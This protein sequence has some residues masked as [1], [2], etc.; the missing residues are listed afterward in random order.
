MWQETLQKSKGGGSGG[1]SR[2][3]FLGQYSSQE[4][5]KIDISMYDV[6]SVDDVIIE[7]TDY[8]GIGCYATMPEIRNVFAIYIDS[9]IGLGTKEINDGILTIS[10]FSASANNSQAVYGYNTI[11][12]GMSITYATYNVY[13]ISN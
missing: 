1:G 8:Q 10:P 2:I 3:N 12:F 9:S 11:P 6:K 7:I 4:E 13:V 5:Q